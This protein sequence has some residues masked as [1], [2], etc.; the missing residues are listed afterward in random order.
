MRN[1]L[2]PRRLRPRHLALAFVCAVL[3]G[4]SQATGEARRGDT[5]FQPLGDRVAKVEADAR[6]PWQ[7]TSSGTLQQ[8]GAIVQAAGEGP[9]S[10]AATISAGGTGVSLRSDCVDTA[11]VPGAWNDGTTVDVLEYGSERCEGWSRVRSGATV[12]W[13]RDDYLAGLPPVEERVAPVA[14][15]TETDPLLVPL[16]A[17][18]NSLSD[19]AGR[20][21]L[22]SR[23]APTSKEAPLTAGFLEDLAADMHALSAE[24]RSAEA[25]EAEACNN[26]Q[27]ALADGADAIADLA[28]GLHVSFREQ[29][30]EVSSALEARV[31]AYVSARQQ[32]A[33][34]VELCA[35]R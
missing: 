14:A 2:H 5:P 10:V 25:S 7:L 35:R 1:R 15:L 6:Y 30:D 9:A 29:Q 32:A 19:G 33:A 18:A 31:S 17:W 27:T 4:C 28:R 8:S 21:A 22:F 16:R 20:F 26:A 34:A 11:R 13:V 23:H 3:A 12:S 24:I